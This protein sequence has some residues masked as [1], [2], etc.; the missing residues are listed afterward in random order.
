MQSLFDAQ[1]PAATYAAT[2]DFE[3]GIRLPP[4]SPG[5]IT[6]LKFWK[7]QGETGTH[8]GRVW[9]DAG[10]LLA[11][12][13]FTN[14]TASGWQQQALPTPLAVAPYTQYMVTVNSTNN[15]YAAAVSALTTELIRDN[16]H[17]PSGSNGLYGFTFGSMPTA[18][19]ADTHYFRD[20]VFTPGR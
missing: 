11:S 15:L 14:E 20:V 6:A 17:A 3:L 8:V 1:T 4:T 12:V 2:N 19:Y 9:N 16:L 7:V 18:T 5:H 10:R 13:T